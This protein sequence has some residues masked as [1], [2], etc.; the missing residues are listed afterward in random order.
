MAIPE[1]NFD[2]ISILY[3]LHDI[4]PDSRAEVLTAL[5]RT[6]KSTGKVCIREPIKSTHGIPVNELRRLFKNAGLREVSCQVKKSEYLGEFKKNA[7][8]R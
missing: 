2:I 4:D 1:N 3:V 5:A 8:Q 7:T 6:L